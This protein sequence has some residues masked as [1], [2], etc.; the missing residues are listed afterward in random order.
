MKSLKKYKYLI[1]M[2]EKENEV[3]LSALLQNML[4]TLKHR[5]LKLLRK[6]GY[7]H[8]DIELV[9]RYKKQ[10]AIVIKYKGND[11][12]ANKERI[13]EIY[14]VINPLLGTILEKTIFF[15]NCFFVATQSTIEELFEKLD[16]YLK[17]DKETLVLLSKLV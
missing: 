9:L 4:N 10:V 2:G 14:K 8:V 1:E 3:K 5:I 6:I 16:T 11:K 13:S 7:S 17:M 12:Y 15:Y